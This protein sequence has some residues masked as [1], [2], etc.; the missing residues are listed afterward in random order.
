[1]RQKI[2]KKSGNYLMKS[3]LVNQAQIKSKKSHQTV[4]KFA[5]KRK[6]LRYLTILLDD[7][8]LYLDMDFDNI[9]PSFLCDII[10]EF[11]PKKS[12]DIDGISMNLVKYI[13]TSISVPLAHIF[14][15]RLSQGVFPDFLKLVE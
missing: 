12:L 11:A 2:Q 3:L 1:M 9:G 4:L 14:S 15:L 5:M 6:W 7:G 8:K 13:S 10:N